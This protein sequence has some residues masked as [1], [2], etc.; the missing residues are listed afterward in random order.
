V[1]P[2]VLSLLNYATLCTNERLFVKEIV[3]GLA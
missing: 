3:S 2:E 1:P